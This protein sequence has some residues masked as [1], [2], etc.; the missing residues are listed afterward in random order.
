MRFVVERLG[1]K[2]GAAGGLPTRVTV[3]SG[4]AAGELFRRGTAP[5]SLRGASR[6]RDRPLAVL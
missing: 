1:C 2:G 5:F 6:K 3:R 4:T